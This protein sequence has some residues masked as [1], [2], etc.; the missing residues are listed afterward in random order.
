MGAS[1]MISVKLYK[2]GRLRLGGPTDVS[3]G[4]PRGECNQVRVRHTYE[5]DAKDETLLTKGRF[6]A[7]FGDQ[8]LPPKLI[9]RPDFVIAPGWL[10]RAGTLRL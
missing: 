10:A 7:A 2:I 9:A 6:V 1:L 3:L 8:W 5:C 4:L